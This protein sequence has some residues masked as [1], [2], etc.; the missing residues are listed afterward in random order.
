MG[1]E[2]VKGGAYGAAGVEDV[3]NE[4]YG[5]TFNADAGMMLCVLWGR[6]CRWARQAGRRGRR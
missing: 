2:C 5:F 6:W 4:D 3:V 1:V